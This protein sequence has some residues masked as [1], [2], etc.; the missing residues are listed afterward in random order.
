M[1]AGH[2]REKQEF[3]RAQVRQDTFENDHYFYKLG[4]AVSL[5][6]K[7]QLEVNI[8]VNDYGKLYKEYSPSLNLPVQHISYRGFHAMELMFLQ[9][10]KTDSD[11]DSLAFQVKLKGS[12][13]R[14]REINNTYQGFDLAL[15]LLWAHQHG[16]WRIHGKVNSEIIGKKEIIQQAGGLEIIDAYSQFG[17][18][19]GL[20]WLQDIYWLE[21]SSLF[22][23]TTDYNSRSPSYNRLTDKGFAVGGKILA[24][25][26]LTPKTV[27]TLEHVKKGAQFNLITES[28]SDANEFEIEIQYTQLGVTW[29]F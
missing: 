16:P 20:Q 21:V 12:P 11:Q 26:Y 18:V 17:A 6:E 4:A 9:Q 5:G 3:E 15:S 29:F 1:R 14:G 23:L 7:K 25:H 22:Y 8:E 19:L 2:F 10:L 27:L 13:L 24:G 28:T